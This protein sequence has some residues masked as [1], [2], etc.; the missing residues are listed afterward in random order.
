[1]F[2]LRVRAGHPARGRR[3]GRWWQAE[4]LLAELRASQGARAE[5]VALAERSRLAREIHDVLAHALSG[6]VLALDTNG[7][8]GRAG[9]SPARPPYT[10]CSTGQP[11]PGGTARDGLDDT[12]QAIAALRGDALPGQLCCWTGGPRHRD[13]GRDLRPPDPSWHR[14]AAAA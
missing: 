10:G 1:M 13:G 3:P 8:A 9:R 11:R 14:T 12:R 4:I 6:L 2:D 7:A 5:A